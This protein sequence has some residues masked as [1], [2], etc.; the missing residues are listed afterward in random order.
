MA[1]YFQLL[2]RQGIEKVGLLKFLNLIVM[3]KI[4]LHLRDYLHSKIMNDSIELDA[5]F[6]NDSEIDL[7]DFLEMASRDVNFDEMDQDIHRFASNPSVRAV[8]E[9]GVDL[10]NYGSKIQANL[11]AAEVDSIND[12]LNQTELVKKLHKELSTCDQEL[13]DMENL[14]K[15]FKGSLGQVATDINNL[16]L[17]S[18]D[19]SIKLNNRKKFEEYLGEF[20]KHISITQNFVNK[21]CYGPVGQS[22]VKLLKELSEK[23]QFIH[24]KDIRKSKA[25]TEAAVPLDKLRIAAANNVRKWIISKV[26]ELRDAYSRDENS[27][28]GEQGRDTP[29]KL[30]IQNS[31]IRCRFL[32]K[33]LI[34][35]APDVQQT[36]RNYY[37]DVVSRIYLDSFR[38]ETR[39]ITSQMAQISISP[40]T[41]VPMPPQRTGYFNVLSVKKPVRQSTLFFSLGE[42]LNLL[43]DI[44]APPQIF[45]FDSYPV[46]ALLRSL[47]QALIDSVTSEVTFS[48][49]F[50]LDD[51]IAT[52]IFAS[53][54]NELELFLDR[55]LYKITDPICIVLLLRFAV[56]HKAEMERR[57]IFKIDQ[58]LINVQR[59]LIER[60]RVIIQMNHQALESADPKMFL[61]NPA[62][63]HHANSMTKRFSE[64]SLSLSKLLPNNETGQNSG[65]NNVTEIVTPEMHTIS[66]AVIDLLER[67]SKEFKTPELTDVFLINNYYLIFYT[68]QSINNCP[69]FELFQQK[70]S[71]C[72]VHFVDLEIQLNFP[73]LV[74]VVRKAFAK[75]ETRED[76]LFINFSENELKNIAIDFKENH[77]KRMMQISES[78]VF[79]FGDFHNGKMI[80]QLIAKRLVLYWVKFDQLCHYLIK[81]SP[82][83]FGNLISTQQLALNIKPMTDSFYSG[84]K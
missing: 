27:I 69:V 81:G 64:F 17:Q 82:A 34:E 44:L 62:T 42:R 53:T 20:T 73:K 48:S 66:A 6:Q 80:L 26:N 36:T 47:Y 2:S 29:D 46:E 84:S 75:L 68:L 9:K 43:K 71:D 13:E 70:L 83:W 23:L 78:Q 56:A 8:L 28:F 14:L 54:T 4:N 45:T 18:N 38:N 65:S 11:E 15:E 7:T 76:P 58:H 77:T 21:I 24:R 33:F 59:K 22:Y 25:V 40:E 67:T 61:E 74:D 63:A 41:I 52:D 16:K 1:V 30:S 3:A 12:Y 49:E 55:L 35:N 50:F 31:M 5:S 51:N 60:F 57:R 10:Q 39:K 32:F 79:K 37:V 72:T 19:I